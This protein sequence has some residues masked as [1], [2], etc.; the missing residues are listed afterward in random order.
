MMCK[1]LA[2]I[3][4]YCKHEWTAGERRGHKLFVTSDPDAPEAVKDRNDEVVLDL[5]RYCGKGEDELT[6]PCV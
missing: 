2:E 5:C 4:A 6:E 3:I 1:K